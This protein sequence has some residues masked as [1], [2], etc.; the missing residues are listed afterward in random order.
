MALL[1][2]TR[3]VA[4]F[5]SRI[6]ASTLA[7]TS[8]LVFV[9]VAL[10]WEPSFASAP[11]TGWFWTTNRTDG[12]VAAVGQN[13]RWSSS[14][15]SALQNDTTPMLDITADCTQNSPAGDKLDYNTAHTDLPNN[16]VFGSND[17]DSS[18]YWEEGQVIIRRESVQS[19]KDY[20]FQVLYTKAQSSA[21]G[22]LNLTYQRSN[23]VFAFDWLE[24][25]NYSY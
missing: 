23:P 25:V 12:L 15:V 10:A 24:L 17:C 8:S 5:R 16:G 9:G 11:Y 6:I 7:V 14:G 19:E 22:H 21:S 4:C 1:W 18:A 13:I 2:V 3:S 20:Y